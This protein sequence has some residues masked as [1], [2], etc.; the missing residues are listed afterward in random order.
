MK[1][2]LSHVS[3]VMSLSVNMIKQGTYRVLSLLG[4]ILVSLQSRHRHEL[5][6]SS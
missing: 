1:L 6:E 2:K 4:L 5:T 3:C